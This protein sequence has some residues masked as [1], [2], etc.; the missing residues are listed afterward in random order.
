MGAGAVDRRETAAGW[1]RKH[2]DAARARGF[3]AVRTR[4]WPVGRLVFRA[5]GIILMEKPTGG[6]R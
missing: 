3:R 6:S 5:S 1:L 2:F 4:R